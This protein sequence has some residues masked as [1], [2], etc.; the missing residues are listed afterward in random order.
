MVNLLTPPYA[1]AN[2]V[3]ALR[4]YL[5]HYTQYQ[6]CTTL[7]AVLLVLVG[8]AGYFLYKS[9]VAPNSDL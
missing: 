9:K 8:L 2:L 3:L 4:P 7:L 6:F 1:R 5:T